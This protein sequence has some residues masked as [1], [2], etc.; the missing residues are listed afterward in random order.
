MTGIL[1]HT[2][3]TVPR[4]ALGK[5]TSRVS[6]YIS[7]KTVFKLPY[8][9]INWTRIQ[10]VCNPR[11]FVP[12]HQS[13]TQRGS[14][15]SVDRVLL[16][17]ASAIS[18]TGMAEAQASGNGPASNADEPLPRVQTL[19][20]DGRVTEIID[21]PPT[22]S[23]STNTRPLSVLVIPGNPG[24]AGFYAEYAAALHGALG[25]RARVVVVGHLGHT[26]SPP[27][28]HDTYSVYSLQDQIQHKVR[29]LEDA[30]AASSQSGDATPDPT[31][32]PSTPPDLDPSGGWVVVGHS[33]GAHVA[34]RLKQKLPGTVR[35]VVGLFP[36]LQFNHQSG[37]QKLL[38]LL[39]SLMPLVRLVSAVASWLVRMLP[40]RTREGL[41]GAVI[42]R[43]WSR[44]AIRSTADGLLQVRGCCRMTAPLG[45][46]EPCYR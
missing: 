21:L 17:S 40:A 4:V 44:E 26:E 2:G 23:D 13:F 39:T 45:D 32:N 30:S 46:T 27:L 6:Y 8:Q 34:L 1:R 33:I 12:V 35:H 19:L 7:T 20:V 10:Q 36:Y 41:V 25:K 37:D 15:K 14:R 38:K 22:A 31:G 42:G 18:Y 28:S 24:L 16:I 11:R 9:S 3:L 29:F 5:Y 43:E